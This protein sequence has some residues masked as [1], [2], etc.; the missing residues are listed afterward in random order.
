MMNSPILGQGDPSNKTPHRWANNNYLNMTSDETKHATAL[1]LVN[2]TDQ[3][4]VSQY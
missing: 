1:E 3:S 2:K 4:L